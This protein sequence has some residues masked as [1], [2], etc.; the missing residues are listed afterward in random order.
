[1]I[2][3]ILLG[4]VLIIIFILILYFSRQYSQ[5]NFSISTLGNEEGTENTKDLY[6]RILFGQQK[7]AFIGSMI[8]A[9]FFALTIAWLIFKWQFSKEPWES[10]AAFSGLVGEL[11]GGTFFWKFYTRID[12]R[13][14]DLL[15]K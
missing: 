11:F 5:P 15:L 13:I 14:K 7:K 2:Y 3:T 1:M 12:D 8:V 6:L 10:V 4:L 9:A